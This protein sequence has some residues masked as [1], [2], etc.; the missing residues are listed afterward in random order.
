[1]W[2]SVVA[3]NSITSVLKF[4]FLL[5]LKN[6]SVFWSFP[7]ILKKVNGIFQNNCY[8]AFEIFNNCIHLSLIEYNMNSFIVKGNKYEPFVELNKEKGIF[9]IKGR[10]IVSNPI[11]FYNPI[12]NWMEEY[13]QNPNDETNFVIELDYFNSSS[14]KA[15]VDLFKVLIKLSD[16]GLIIDW[17]TFEDDD[18]I[19]EAKKIMEITGVKINFIFID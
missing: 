12:L 4:K 5:F 19:D 18:I 6:S 7:F 13:C 14:F 1:M 9:Q 16:K 17:H 11:E 10:S 2:Y 15:L 8:I 3:D